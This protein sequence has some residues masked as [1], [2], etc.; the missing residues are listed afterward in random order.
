[1]EVEGQPNPEETPIETP[2]ATGEE[3]P[4]VETA[5]PEEGAPSLEEPPAYEPNLKFKVHGEEKEFD[6]WA[7]GLVK[8]PESEQ[9]FREIM[10][11]VHGIDYIKQDRE[12]LR[13]QL[14]EMQEFQT[15]YHNLEQDINTL[16]QFIQNKNFDAFFQMTQI[17]EQDILQWA[18]KRLQYYEMSPEQ[19]QEYDRAVQAQT[20]EVY[21]GQHAQTLEQQMQALKYEQNQFRL[22]QHLTQ[23]G[24]ADQVAQYDQR[25]GQGAFRKAVEERGLY[26]YYQTGQDIPVEQAVQE[27]MQIAGMQVNNPVQSPAP[28][29][30]PQ[31]TPQTPPSAPPQAQKKPVIPKVQ[32]SGTSPVKP[33]VRSIEDLKK[34]AAA[35]S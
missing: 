23:P 22:D 5:P 33:G 27:V 28:M 24:I 14:T 34:L 17:K 31:A 4:P 26:H 12:Q 18:A 11:K 7:K 29:G 19:R 32:G 13:E 20:N 16:D 1:M 3:T 35:R 2:E 30:T 9:Q 15:K 21:F 8:D 6:D 25:L 10:E